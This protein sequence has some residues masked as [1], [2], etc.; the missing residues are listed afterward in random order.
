MIQNLNR[1]EIYEIF[2]V[3]EPNCMQDDFID[4]FLNMQE[5]SKNSYTLDEI[6]KQCDSSVSK[7]I[8]LMKD[9]FT[10]YIRE[11]YDDLSK[12][13]INLLASVHTQD[14][15]T[16]IKISKKEQELLAQIKIIKQ[17]LDEIS[18]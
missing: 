18:K 13:Y 10:T 16:T 7:G 11:L 17:V 6:N 12:K 3:N 9:K 2:N 8:F 15:E 5:E 4:Y 14:M 1:Q